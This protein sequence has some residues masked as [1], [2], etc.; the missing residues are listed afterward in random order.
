MPRTVEGAT[1][2]GQSILNWIVCVTGRLRPTQSRTLATLVATLIRL[3]RLNLAQI[4]RKINARGTAKVDSSAPTA[5][6][7]KDTTLLSLANTEKWRRAP[8][9][10]S[11]DMRNNSPT[12]TSSST[13][14]SRCALV[15]ATLLCPAAP[16]TS[17]SDQPPASA[18]LTNVWRPW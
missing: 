6:S 4:S 14:T 1:V 2:S 10:G 12:A 15:T 7:E 3:D 9:V 11:H 18:W 17:A 16:R 13:T 5:G 8:G